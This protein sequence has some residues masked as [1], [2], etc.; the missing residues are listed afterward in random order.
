MTAG[1]VRQPRETNG[2]GRH[3]G[4]GALL[5]DTLQVLGLLATEALTVAELAE[6]TS[7][8]WR[9]VYRI[10]DG[11]RDAGIGLS[12]SDKPARAKGADPTRFRVPRAEL[13]R[14]LGV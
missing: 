10:L 3:R 11:I 12:E 5:R 6:R 1:T 14:A 4:R 8:H 2:T 13:A 7:I 9:T